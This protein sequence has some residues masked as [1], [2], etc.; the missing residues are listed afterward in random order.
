M[1]QLRGPGGHWYAG[2]P[3]PRGC[4]IPNALPVDDGLG[5][6]CGPQDV[7][8]LREALR[9]LLAEE[10]AK[11]GGEAAVEEEDKEE[12]KRPLPSGVAPL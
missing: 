6:F 2:E 7:W 10:Q 4:A 8:H 3:V 11:E 12:Q 5:N 9:G 1:P